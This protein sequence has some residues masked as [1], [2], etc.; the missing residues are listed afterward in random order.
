M[1]GIISFLFWLWVLSKLIGFLSKFAKNAPNLGQNSGYGDY[2]N[3]NQKS[4]FDINDAVFLVKLLAKVARANGVVR[5]EEARYVSQMLDLIAGELGT[6]A[7]RQRLKFYFNDAKDNNESPQNIA[8]V[9]ARSKNLSD[10]YKID[11]LSYL[12]ELGAIDGNLDEKESEII[13]QV[14]KGFGFYEDQI[15]QIFAEFKRKYEFKHRRTYSDYSSYGGQSRQKESGYYRQNQQNSRTTSQ[16]MDYARACEILGVSQSDD[17][18]VIK[19]AYRKL[20]L[21]YHPDRGGSEEK[22]KEIND[23]Y[24]IIKDR[25]GK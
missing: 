10:Q 12:F 11:I 15:S 7:Y 4:S 16:T 18:E 6:D 25:K 3:Y 9:Y 17:F 13:Y 21:K 8:F 2:S 22:M 1:F 24:E 5:E 19:K 23:A 14:C 20:A